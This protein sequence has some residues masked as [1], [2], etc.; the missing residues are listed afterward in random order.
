VEGGSRAPMEG[1]SCSKESAAKASC[2]AQSLWGSCLM[3]IFKTRAT[4]SFLGQGPTE[5]G[6]VQ[7]HS[8]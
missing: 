1:S 6:A 7:T 4:G 2:S 3:I 5:P 8:K